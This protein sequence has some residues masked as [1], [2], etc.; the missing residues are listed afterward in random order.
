[1][2]S[3]P[4]IYASSRRVHFAKT[5]DKAAKTELNK[6]VESA[7]ICLNGNIIFRFHAETLLDDAVAT[8]ERFTFGKFGICSITNKGDAETGRKNARKESAIGA[9]RY[10][11]CQPFSPSHW[12]FLS[13]HYFGMVDAGC[14]YVETTKDAKFVP[15]QS[16]RA[17]VVFAPITPV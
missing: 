13:V 5:F 14:I 2:D 3:D 4:G 7:T 9:N 16:G 12:R 6:G 1:M 11:N 17:N 8:R 15:V 10:T